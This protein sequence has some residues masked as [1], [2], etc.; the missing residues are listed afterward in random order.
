VCGRF[1]QGFDDTDLERLGE[2]V[3]G[4]VTTPGFAPRTSFNI[5]PTHDATIIRR[6]DDRPVL[7]EARFGLV[8]SW[9]DDE[10]IASRLINARA[11]SVREKPAYKALVRAGRAI[12]PMSGFYEWQ[13]VPGERAK[14]PWYITRADTDPL[15][16]GA[17]RDT[18][19]QGGSEL[20]S[21][22][23]ITRPAGPFV[24]TIHDRMP[25]IVRP[26]DA[27]AW[28]DRG[29][30][31]S[32]IDAILRADPDAE[33]TGHRVARRVGSPAHDDAALIE[34]NTDG[35]QGSLFG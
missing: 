17:L 10:S 21:F 2:L 24:A 7:S 26:D 8:P 32:T 20:D 18:W 25:L 27:A 33:L 6:D 31:E 9:A 1:V 13:G 29:S 11:E 34:E 30:D 4:L 14:R 15:L 16:V 3:E 5:A 19:T 12:V 28:L 23:I 35:D 22:S